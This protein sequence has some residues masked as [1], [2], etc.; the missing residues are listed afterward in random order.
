MKWIGVGLLAAIATLLVA[1]PGF[2]GET[3]HGA[4]PGDEA[5]D[6][7]IRADAL[8]PGPARAWIPEARSVVHTVR[9]VTRAGARTSL[10]LLLSS[11]DMRRLD[12]MK[13]DEFVSVRAESDTGAEWSTT[14][15]SPMRH[16]EPTRSEA[17]FIGDP[18]EW[19]AL[20][21]QIDALHGV[22][23]AAR[24]AL[25]DVRVL[26]PARGASLGCRAIAERALVIA[27]SPS[28]FEAEGVPP[29]VARGARMLLIG[30]GWGALP[31]EALGRPVPWGMGRLAFSPAIDSV[32][33][34][35]A[36]DSIV[37]ERGLP[38]H[39]ASLERLFRMMRGSTVIRTDA[40][41]PV[42]MKQVLLLLAGYVLLIGPAGYA[43]G[44]LTRKTW[45]AWAWFPLASLGGAAAILV[46]TEAAASRRAEVHLTEA[47][48]TDARGNGLSRTDAILE[49]GESEVYDLSTAWRDA[50]LGPLRR[51]FRFGSPFARPAGPIRLDEDDGAGTMSMQGLA[52]NRRGALPLSWVAPVDGTTVPEVEWR[53]TEIWLKNP[54]P[55][56]LSNARLVLHGR[57]GR[58][59]AIAGGTRK[60][61]V[62]SNDPADRE[63]ERF[64]RDWVA[65][66]LET[67]APSDG[68]LLIAEYSGARSATLRISPKILLV[69]SVMRVVVGPAPGGSLQEA[70]P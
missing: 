23:E 20:S 3:W 21:R 10:R 48:I 51:P 67:M 26:T 56:M 54:T 11:E 55:Q 70:A 52:V 44:R 7:D 19:S 36:T 1:R 5:I 38:M 66:P 29:C 18:D 41:R 43:I 49:G 47:S 57:I 4:D 27:A 37:G 40:V 61:I 15:A 39:E 25:G 60:K 8:P 46:T 31:P 14:V 22:T 42:P 45:L 62:F 59:S 64:M 2:A 58:V 12:M 28:G 53:G 13:V 63:T 50:D 65:W 6:V 32:A 69:P 16:W 9:F 35:A 34:R 30:Q 33:A 24:R 68:Y 17:V